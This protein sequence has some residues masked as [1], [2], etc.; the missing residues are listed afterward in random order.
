[1]TNT[2]TP[3]TPKK[4]YT[5][6]VFM[7]IGL[8][9]AL[10]GVDHLTFNILPIGAKTTI[11]GH[12]ITVS[13]IDSNNDSTALTHSNMQPGV[14]LPGG[15]T[16]S[17]IG[18]HVTIKQNSAL[19]YLIPFPT[20]LTY[21]TV[22]AD[23]GENVQIQGANAWIPKTEFD[24]YTAYAPNPIGIGDDSGGGQGVSTGN[25]INHYDI[26]HVNSGGGNNSI[27]SEVPPAANHIKP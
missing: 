12:D 11:T 3:E 23:N 10:V 20:G 15:I 24:I 21:F 26:N 18:R 27:H 22:S 7:V 19:F 25:H 9:L 8:G 13:P 6:I 5:K 17:W 2:T 16:R 14:T 4:N 1:M